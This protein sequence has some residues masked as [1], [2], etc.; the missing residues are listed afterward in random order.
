MLSDKQLLC[1]FSD[2]INYS[3]DI[4]NIQKYYELYDNK[5]FIFVNPNS[6]KEVFL[7]YNVYKKHL[8]EHYKHTIGIHR[9]KQTNTLYTLNAMNKLIAD[10]NDGVFNCNYQL[11]WENYKNSI[12]LTNDVGVKIVEL[13]LF[14]IFSL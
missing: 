3:E 14:S 8:Y 5:I 12:L 1:T 7:T 6:L 2:N 11:H 13:K 4:S 9:K 10:E